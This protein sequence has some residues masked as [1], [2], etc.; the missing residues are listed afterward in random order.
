MRP[1]SSTITSNGV[2]RIWSS[3]IPYLFIGLFLMMVLIAI[4]LI[5]LVC[6]HRKSSGHNSTSTMMMTMI[7]RPEKFDMEPKV[8]VI[9]PGD[10]LPRFLAK[11]SSSSSSI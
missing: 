10:D 4:A 2:R 3:P 7:E 8:V 1:I 9:M 5:I 11:P 6:S